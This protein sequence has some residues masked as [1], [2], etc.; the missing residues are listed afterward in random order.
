MADEEG[1]MPPGA[2]SVP[3]FRSAIEMAVD[4][5][6][7]AE[8]GVGLEVART[9]GTEPQTLCLQ[10]RDNEWVHGRTSFGVVDPDSRKGSLGLGVHSS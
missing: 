8:G 10:G 3:G 5:R 6:I 2:A 9:E 1:K 4:L 7:G